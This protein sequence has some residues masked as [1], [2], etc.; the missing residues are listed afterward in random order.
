MD[1]TA[2]LLRV[3]LVDKQ[4]RGLKSRLAAAE[5]FL[6]SQNKELDGINSTRHTLETQ[7]RGLQAQIA[8]HEGEM[9]RLDA[10]M[11]TI[12]GQMDQAQTNKEYK[13]FL[14]EMN[15]FKT[16]RDKLETAALEFMAKADE[17]RKQVAELE[18]KSKERSQVRDVAATERDQRSSEIADRLKELTAERVKLAAEVPADIMVMYQ[19][20]L[21]QRGD[22]AMASVEVQDRKR[23]EFTCG[24]CM[25]TVPVDSVSGLMSG[26][27]LTTCKSCQCLLYMDQEAVKAMQPVGSKR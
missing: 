23:H 11:A 26:G 20:L 6:G 5:K 22:D 2:K 14:T 17:L 27:K 18:S 21:D 12:R 1:V 16:D 15:T 7:L 25:M 8:D 24:A 10:R 3:F 13:A 4:L 9:K 19:R